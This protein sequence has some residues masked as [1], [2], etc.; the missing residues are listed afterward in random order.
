MNQLGPAERYGE[1]ESSEAGV[2][3]FT[4]FAFISIILSLLSTTIIIPFFNIPVWGG[5]GGDKMG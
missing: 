2:I 5:K 3:P 1:G 4:T